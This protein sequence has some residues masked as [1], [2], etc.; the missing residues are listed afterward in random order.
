MFVATKVSLSRQNYVCRDKRFVATSILLSRRVCLDKF[1]VATKMIFVAALA[2][3]RGERSNRACSGSA[4]FTD[5][6]VQ[7]PLS[8]VDVEGDALDDLLVGVT[9]LD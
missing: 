1:F 6:T 7:H 5:L 3:D 2:N 8:V 9:M 4:K